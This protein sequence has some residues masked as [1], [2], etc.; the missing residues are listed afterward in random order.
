M[1]LDNL[2][3]EQHSYDGFTLRAPSGVVLREGSTIG[4]CTATWLRYADVSAEMLDE[5]RARRDRGY[6]MVLMARG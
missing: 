2:T 4:R 1:K 5:R 3:L 6:H